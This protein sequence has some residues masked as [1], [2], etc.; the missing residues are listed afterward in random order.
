VSQS[1]AVAELRIVHDRLAGVLADCADVHVVWGPHLAADD[2]APAAALRAA[3]A[4]WEWVALGFTGRSFWDLHV[5][6]LP[7][8]AGY[9][10]GLHWTSTLDREVRPWA[11]TA[12][13]S[14]ALHF[15]EVAAEHQLLC[16]DAAGVTVHSTQS[17]VEAALGIASRVLAGSRRSAGVGTSTMHERENKCG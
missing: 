10:V 6:M 12:V 2:S 17:A 9:T 13:P 4:G 14:G 15:A 7:V 11:Q 3:G 16:A 8:E 1:D 5:G